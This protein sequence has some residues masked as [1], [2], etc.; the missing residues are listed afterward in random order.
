MQMEFSGM[1]KKPFQDT[2]LILVHTVARG[3][4]KAIINKVFHLYLNKVQKINSA[5]KGS[6]QKWLQG[7]F[8]NC[9]L[10]IQ[11]Q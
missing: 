4:H 7:L 6:L 11:A 5:E 8:L 3:D 9:M 1:S 10:G 2:L